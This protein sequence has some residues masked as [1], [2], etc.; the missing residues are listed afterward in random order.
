MDSNARLQPAR[1]FASFDEYWPYYLQ[2][3]SK[4]ETR[5]LHLAGTTIAAMGLAAWFATSQKRYLAL[6]L[7]GS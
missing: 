7:F 4:P 2:E 5:A 6:S 1:V 3:H